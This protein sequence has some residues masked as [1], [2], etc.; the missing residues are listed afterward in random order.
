[1]G[2]VSHFSGLKAQP[3]RNETEVLGLLTS[4]KCTQILDPPQAVA[5]KFTFVSIG[6]LELKGVI[7]GHESLNYY[8]CCPNCKKK[9][10]KAGDKCTFCAIP[11]NGKQP[12]FDF[13]V[14]FLIADEYKDKVSKVSAF[15]SHL[16][17]EFNSMSEAQAEKAVAKLHMQNVMI[18][19][20]PEETTDSIRVAVFT[21]RTDSED[22]FR[23]SGL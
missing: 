7:L 16:G 17:F 13:N 14:L 4:Q 12:A 5:D 9:N 21:V 22:M 8:E 23:D 6:D 19:Y 18:E 20:D 15:R 3:P 11:L 1:M 10:Y 2:K